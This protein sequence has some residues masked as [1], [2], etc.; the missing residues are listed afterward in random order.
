[1]TETCLGSWASGSMPCPAGASL[2]PSSRFN[3][4]SG[5]HQAREQTCN[6]LSQAF[7]HLMET[8]ENSPSRCRSPPQG[9]RDEVRPGRLGKLPWITCHLV[10][11]VGFKPGLDSKAPAF[12]TDPI[13]LH[14]AEL[15]PQAP[16][17]ANSSVS[18]PQALK[19]SS[20]GGS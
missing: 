13:S 20:D 4:C 18:G 10:M 9:A 16:L 5:Y 3:L 15:S 12:P 14:A 17:P 8:S 19:A 6:C 1:M 7:H 11:E 2:G